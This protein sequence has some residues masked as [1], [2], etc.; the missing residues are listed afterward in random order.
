MKN[1]PA[2]K[3]STGTPTSNGKFSCFRAAVVGGDSSF[4]HRLNIGELF[5]CIVFLDTPYQGSMNIEQTSIDS[6]FEQYCET[7]Y[8]LHEQHYK[9]LHDKEMI[10][11]V[12]S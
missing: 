6:F 12:G 5:T 11:I 10:K 9:E 8:L 3:K 1:P 7:W 2:R 4:H